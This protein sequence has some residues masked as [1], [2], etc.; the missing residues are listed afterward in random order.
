MMK[1]FLNF[2][3][4]LGLTTTLFLASCSDDSSFFSADDSENFV[5]ESVFAIQANSVSGKGGCLELIFPINII[6]PDG[7]VTEVSDHETLRSE[8]KAWY[9][10]NAEELGLPAQ[11]NGHKGRRQHGRDSINIDPSLLPTLDF[12]I[13]AITS[14]GE[15]IS[16]ADRAELFTLKRECKRDMRRT[17]RGKA[18][19][20]KPTFP[21]TVDFPDGTSAE[22]EDRSAMKAGLRAW[23]E[24]N[25]DASERPTLQFPVT[26]ELEDG[27]TQEVGSKEDLEALKESCAS[28]NG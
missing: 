24:A 18:K 27:T 7:A 8:L 1:N 11:G 6:F 15:T 3:L 5:D 12:P 25:P 2:F 26:V 9:E 4:F 21:L 14:E 17:R 10:A 22:Y 28:D 23:K 19:C 16:I 20:F 13:E